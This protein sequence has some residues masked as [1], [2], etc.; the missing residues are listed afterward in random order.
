MEKNCIVSQSPQRT[1]V[2]EKKKKK[3]KSICL[4]SFELWSSEILSLVCL[5]QTYFLCNSLNQINYLYV[6]FP[7]SKIRFSK[8]AMS[9]LD[10][11]PFFRI[12]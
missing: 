5:K 4:C 2:L 1:V 9:E 12:S 7:F 10:P 8:D 6:K 3:K 11:V